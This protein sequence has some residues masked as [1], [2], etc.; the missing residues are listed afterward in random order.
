MADRIFTFNELSTADLVVDAVYQGQGKA[1]TLADEPL[2]RLLPVGNQGG[3]RYNGSKTDITKCRMVVLFSSLAD[4]DWPDTLHEETGV[5]TYFG[6]NKSPGSELHSTTRSGNVLLRGAFDL[7]HQSSPDRSHIPPFFVFTAAGR[8]RDVRFR[9][10]AVPGSPQVAETD[11]LVAVWKTKSGKRFQN[12]KA[13]FTILDIAKVERKWIDDLQ[14]KTAD[15]KRAPAAYLKWLKTG[16]Y[17]ALKAPRTL[18]FRRR[19]DQL[20]ASS[21]AKEI[22]KRIHQHFPRSRAYDFEKCAAQ[23]VEWM[24]NRVVRIDVTRP[25]RDGGRDAVGEYRIGTPND[26]VT[27]EFAMEAKCNALANGCGIRASSRLISRLRHRQFGVF[28]TTSYLAEQAYKEVRE[29]EHPVLVISAKE[30]VEILA[31][32]GLQ[33]P[34]DVS[35]W[36]ATEFP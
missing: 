16:H 8:S 14:A 10:V 3:F 20:P 12:Y 33:T 13:I 29:D 17:D 30:I 1:Q 19:D 25:W 6:D 34:D 15:T 26:Y 32:R 28:V 2:H 7:L 11:D 4:P 31:S 35:K 23:I 9:G 24:D 36:L 5:F 18:A 21:T 27:V 22:V